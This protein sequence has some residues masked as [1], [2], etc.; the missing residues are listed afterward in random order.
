MTSFRKILVS[1]ETGLK[2]KYLTVPPA[3]DKSAWRIIRYCYE[4]L[5]APVHPGCAWATWGSNSWTM[6]TDWRPEIQPNLHYSFS[7]ITATRITPWHS[8]YLCMSAMQ[9][10]LWSSN[11][12]SF[13][14]KHKARLLQRRETKCDTWESRR[15]SCAPSQRQDVL[16]VADGST[17]RPA[18]P[19]CPAD[20]HNCAAANHKTTFSRRALNTQQRFTN[21]DSPLQ[22]KELYKLFLGF[23]YSLLIGQRMLLLPFTPSVN[24]DKSVLSPYTKQSAHPHDSSFFYLQRRKDLGSTLRKVPINQQQNHIIRTIMPQKCNI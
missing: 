18:Q 11:K 21:P 6:I 2:P 12:P 14:I 16:P 22:V 9:T 10:M 4:P 19:V 7:I 8:N 5:S 17:D 15:V 24:V 20:V 13:Y 3:T 1:T 23:I